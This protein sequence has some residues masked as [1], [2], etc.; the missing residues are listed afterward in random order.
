M[1]ETILNRGYVNHQGERPTNVTC[2]TADDEF[3]DIEE[4]KFVI[5]IKEESKISLVGGKAFNLSKMARKGIP[6]PRGFC[7]T[8][9]VYDYFIDFNNISGE[10]SSDKIREGLMP[11]C[12]RDIITNAYE[13]YLNGRACAVRSSSPFEDLKSASFAGQY[14]SFLNVKGETL[15]D[16]VKECWASAWSRPAAEYRKKMGIDGKVAMAVLVQEMVPAEASGVLFT[17]DDMVVEAVWGLGDILVGGTSAADRFVVEREGFTVLK[18]TISHKQLMSQVTS[19]GGVKE[20]VVPD[21]L[22]DQPALNDDHLQKLCTL[23]KKVDELFGC[24]QD[25]EWALHNNNIV[26]LQ[27]RPITVKQTP[28]IWSRANIAETQP[29]YVTYLSRIPENRP[30]FFVVGVLP[31][32]ERFGIKKLPDDTKFLEYIYGHIYANITNL[33]KIIGSIPGLP[34]SV[35]DQSIGFASEEEGSNPSLETLTILKMSFRICKVIHFFMDLPKMASRVIP[36]SLNLI[37]DIRHRNLE[38]LTLAELDELIWK[39]YDA[40][41]AVFQIHA[42]TMLA[43]ML[44]FGIFQKLL[45]RVGETGN[46]LITGLEGMSSFRLGAEMWKLAQSASTSPRV[47]A[48][49]LSQKKNVL[50]E[51]NQFSEGK[52]FLR[53]LDTFME[54]YGDRCSQEMELSVPRWKENLSFVFSIVATY[55]S[56]H[57]PDPAETVEAQKKVRLETTDRILKDL[58]KNPLEKLIFKKILEK[59]QEY[60][61]VR[62]NLKTA[63][64]RG[65]S[66]MRVLYLAIASRLVEGGILANT[67]DIFYLKMTE[68]SEIIAGNLKREQLTFIEERKKEKEECEHLD[69]PMMMEGKPL[70]I[71]ELTC[72]VELKEILEGTGCSHG[73]VTGRARV[74]LSPQE[75]SDFAEGDILVAPVT[76]PGWS[77]L[78]VTAGGLVMELGGVLSHGV[79]IARE[80][81]IPAVVGV[82][83]ATKI[84]K[85][86]QFITVDGS[87]GFIYIRNDADDITW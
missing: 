68:V 59:T 15:P 73:V 41:Q 2:D 60:L 12:L 29:G 13:K 36:H 25:I 28:T 8:T 26:I 31:L 45:A 58:S 11:A 50:E 7:I 19:E 85:T 81:G 78:F 64:V 23:G 42:N 14:K 72:R 63:W 39:I 9:E 4:P 6:V 3:T 30:D 55:L 43:N 75:C 56:T 40:N 5:R 79:I 86:G 82:K 66:A 83:D 53:E 38:E 37:K 69:V 54:E 16:A 62:E 47:S 46:V 57:P 35:I 87:K 10:E 34:P 17:E 44:L 76:D 20:R 32:L 1:Q 52:E 22:Q 71:K 24:P 70:P 84:I 67:D 77:P 27:A 65:I 51:L 18:R 49:I 61:V 48:L 21:H 33:H 80:Y 74:V